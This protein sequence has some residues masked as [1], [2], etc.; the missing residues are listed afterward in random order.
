MRGLGVAWRMQG[1]KTSKM[2]DFACVSQL[3]TNVHKDILLDYESAALTVELW[4][5][6]QAN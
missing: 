1:A 4:A 2:A 5:R 6:V 3:P